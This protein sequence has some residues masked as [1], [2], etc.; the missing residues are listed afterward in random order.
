[1]QRRVRAGWGLLI[2][3]VLVVAVV[4]TAGAFL[5]HGDASFNKWVGWATIA[6]AAITAVSLLLLLWEKIA[7]RVASA[8]ISTGGTEDELAAAVLDEAR[9]ARSQLIG[10]D[11]AGDQPANVRFVR[12]SGRLRQVGGASDGDLATVLEYYQSLAPGRLVVLGE[13]GAGKTVLAIELLIRL[14]ERRRRDKTMPVPVLISAAAYDTR[15]TWEKW[16]AGHLVLRF[17]ISPAAA[18]R[19]V[20]DRRILPLVDGLD[21]MDHADGEAVRALVLVAAL[22]NRCTTGSAHRSWSPAAVLSMRR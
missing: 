16:L 19:L 18:A 1:M 6:G 2:L 13:P 14:L 17:A 20:R 11:E 7:P 5:A 9:T 8:E 10:V 21:E 4:P 3:A 15:L 22:N 12:C